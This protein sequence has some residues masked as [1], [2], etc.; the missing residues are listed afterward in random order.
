MTMS[1]TA[2]FRQLWLD[3]LGP[4]YFRS[5]QTA[6][7]ESRVNKASTISFVVAAV[8]LFAANGISNAMRRLV[9]NRSGRSLRLLSMQLVREYRAQYGQD[10]NYW[11]YLFAWLVFSLGMVGFALFPK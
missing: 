5:E 1:V 2:I 4:C 9:Y 7:R 8:G 10:R 11:A 3:A 6:R